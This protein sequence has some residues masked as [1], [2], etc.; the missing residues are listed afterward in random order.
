MN[1]VRLVR[2]GDLE[3]AS[4]CVPGQQFEKH[5]HDEFVIGAN[6]VG[7]ER[8]WLDGR[9][10]D[11]GVGAITTYNPG[12]IQGG[13]AREG[14][15]WR[16]VSLYLPA[17]RLAESLGRSELQFERP[18]QQ[19]PALAGELARAIET[20]LSDDPLLREHGEEWVT[21]LLGRIA[22]GAG[23]RLAATR[24][25]GSAA[26]ARL[27]EL[28]AASLEQTPSLEQMAAAVGLSRFHLLRAFKRRTGLSPRQWAMQLRTR[29]AQGL[30]RLGVPAGEVAHA[31][32]F[33][34]QSHLNRHF[35]AAYGLS[36]GRYQALVRG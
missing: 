28:L 15:P 34:D 6:L 7:E 14:Q 2:L 10:F 25:V 23:V 24:D 9:T 1:S 18:L 20:C 27:Q 16:Y 3:V 21:L 5:S 4:S 8:I 35:R 36:P 19:A 11:A 26:V 29:R 30:L 13:G 17:D 32:G 31:L 12:E 33:A 22:S